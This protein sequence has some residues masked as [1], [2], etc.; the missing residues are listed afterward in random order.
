M[1]PTAGT[2]G[3][4]EMVFDTIIPKIATH[5]LINLY[6]AAR[7]IRSNVFQYYPNSTTKPFAAAAS[8][9]PIP[10][11][12]VHK[13]VVC[14]FHGGLLRS[15]TLFPYFMLVA[16]E[17]GSLLRALL[18]LCSFP[19]VWALGEHAG[20]G[21]RVM[22]FVTF[23][24][25]RPRDADLVARAVL[26]KFYMERLNAQVYD[27]LWLP[28][29]RKVVVTSAPRVM[30]EWF[31]KQYM[32]ADVVVGWELRMVKVGRRCYFTGML[33]RPGPGAPALRELFRADDAMA[34]VGSSNQVD[35]FFVPY[36]STMPKDVSNGSRT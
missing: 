1:K 20:A 16:F 31:L 29:R 34:V 30:A 12:A 11:S 17:G 35:H 28:A 19:L 6:R 5:W 9:R 22:A 15:T 26:P 18:L 4:K 7:K 14:D 13:T 24:G 25:L 3:G 33:C 36:C 2:A 32:A 8:R 27:H 23:V 10:G 21:V